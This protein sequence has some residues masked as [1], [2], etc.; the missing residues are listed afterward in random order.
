MDWLWAERL[1]TEARDRESITVLW[2]EGKSTGREGR[3]PRRRI[4]ITALAWPRPMP[5]NPIPQPLITRPLVYKSQALTLLLGPLLFCLL[6]VHCC[7]YSS[8][9][10]SAY[11]SACSWLLRL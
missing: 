7:H 6:A 11:L 8:S 10:A 1:S 5:S 4:P 9:S 2:Q 3:C